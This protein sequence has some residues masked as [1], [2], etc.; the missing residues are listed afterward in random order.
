[1][2]KLACD[3]ANGYKIDYEYSYGYSGE[4][5]EIMDENKKSLYRGVN[6]CSY[7]E[8]PKDIPGKE[9]YFHYKNDNYDIIEFQL[10]Y[11]LPKE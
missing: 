7:Y 4:I 1:M 3:G 6:T 5:F 8:M 2:V 9:F 10:S 11:N